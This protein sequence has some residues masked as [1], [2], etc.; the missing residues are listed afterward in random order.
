MMTMPPTTMKTETMPMAMPEIVA[1][2]RSQRLTM[3]SEAK[4]LKLSS[5]P[6]L[7]WR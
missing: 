1:V 2:S 4:R 3:V 7:R 5:W 6:G